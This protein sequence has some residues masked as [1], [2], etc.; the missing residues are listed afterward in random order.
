M[1]GEKVT[2]GAWVE[3]V[4]YSGGDDIET[5]PLGVMHEP[6]V[7][8]QSA[9]GTSTRTLGSMP[10]VEEGKYDPEALAEAQVSLGDPRPQENRFFFALRKLPRKAK[11]SASEADRVMSK[12]AD[13]AL[14]MYGIRPRK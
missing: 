3:G 6:A 13:R 7:P 4:L 11:T 8:V 1:K 5:Q 12:A 14:K 2:T 9:G 10:L